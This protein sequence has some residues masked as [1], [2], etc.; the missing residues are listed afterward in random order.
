MSPPVL[1]A[2]GEDRDGR[3][4]LGE[5]AVVLGVP[6]TGAVPLQAATRGTRLGERAGVDTDFVV[7]EGTVVGATVTEERFDVAVL[8]AVD[9]KLRHVPVHVEGEVPHLRIRED[10]VPEGGAGERCV[11]EAE[12][13]DCVAVCGGM[14]A[15]RPSPVASH[16]TGSVSRRPRAAGARASRTADTR[17]TRW[18]RSSV[19]CC[20]G[21]LAGRL[22]VRCNRQT[23]H[24]HL[25]RGQPRGQSAGAACGAAVRRAHLADQ[26]TPKP[27]PSPTPRRRRGSSATGH[28]TCDG[29]QPR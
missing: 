7:G 22:V 25:V 23:Q 12:M 16:R 21:G 10:A 28:P 19:M 1:T 4:L 9:E 3:R 17:V 8:P 29:E 5:L 15:P 27:S 11:K 2:K 24:I 6:G 20:P 14:E 18:A 13:A 26:P